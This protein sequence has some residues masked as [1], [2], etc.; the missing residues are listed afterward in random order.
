MS[1]SALLLW[2]RDLFWFFVCVQLGVVKPQELRGSLAKLV[3]GDSGGFSVQLCYRCAGFT[4][5]LYMRGGFMALPCPVDHGCDHCARCERTCLRHLEML[6]SD[7]QA[8]FE[9]LHHFDD[10]LIIDRPAKTRLQ[11]LNELG[12]DGAAVFRRRLLET[13]IELRRDSEIH[14]GVGSGHAPKATNHRA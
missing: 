6:L 7:L 5:P 13:L 10:L 8:L 2:A 11:S 12:R 1:R 14:L 4:K 3:T 9:P